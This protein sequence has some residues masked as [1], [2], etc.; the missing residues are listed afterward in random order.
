[1]KKS[2]FTAFAVGLGLT[3]N[4]MAQVPS[5]VPTNGLVGWWPFN[6]NANDESGNGNNGTVNG[7][8]LTVDRFGNANKAYSFDGFFSEIIVPNSSSFNF[9]NQISVSLWFKIN[10]LNMNLNQTLY[11][12]RLIDKQTPNVSADGFMIDCIKFLSSTHPNY[13]QNNNETKI[14]T[15]FG[16][17]NNIN[18]SNFSNCFD[19]SDWCNISVTFLDGN[20]K[21]YLNGQILLNSVCSNSSLLNNALN[22]VFG[23]TTMS[24]HE[25]THFN[26]NID[27]IGIWNRA[28]SECEIQD[29]Y[30]A[31]INSVTGSISVSPQPATLGSS[32]S[33]STVSQSPQ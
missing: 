4:V 7:A 5:Y 17:Q 12:G 29:L 22:L 9:S 11:S 14:R 26:G 30:N 10:S 20:Q 8:I 2:L 27:D 6:G 32:V 15:I 23:H 16:L 13:C 21:I 24:G 18:C 19:Y 33:L 1:M 31:Q 28:L 3:V 25:D